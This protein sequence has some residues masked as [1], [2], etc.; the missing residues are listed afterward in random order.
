MTDL[1]KIR[2]FFKLNLQQV[3][4]YFWLKKFKRKVMFSNVL[5]FYFLLSNLYKT[6][7]EYVS[8]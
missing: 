8:V 1:S 7:Q 2:E 5:W 6:K 3:Y 4:T